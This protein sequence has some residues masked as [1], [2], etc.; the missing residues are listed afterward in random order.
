MHGR[1]NS[2]NF[3]GKKYMYE[4]LTKLQEFYMIIARKIFSRFFAP[5]RPVSCACNTVQ[6]QLAGPCY[7]GTRLW[8]L[9]EVVA[10]CAVCTCSAY[11][12]CERLK[13]PKSRCSDADRARYITDCF[14]SACLP[15]FH[16]DSSITL[17]NT[18]MKR[19]VLIRDGNGSS[20][21]IHDPCDPSHS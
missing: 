13:N 12:R 8:L 9:N 14:F 3:L 16:D 1:R 7:P 19:T 18:H 15:E 21:V 4:I 2:V 6:C 20:F 17:R 10:I 11:C 5:R